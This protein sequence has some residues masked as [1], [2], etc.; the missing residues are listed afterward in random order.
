MSDGA[1]TNAL[2]LGEPLA[3]FLCSSSWFGRES[4]RV[5]YSAFMPRNGAT[6]V[7]RV[8]GLDDLEVWEIG[9]RLVAGPAGRSLHGH[10]ALQVVHVKSC[11][12]ILRADDS[13]PRHAE[14]LGWPEEKGAQR[15]AAERLAAG[16][17]LHLC[18]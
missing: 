11:S 6:S 1:V 17:D 10:A 7:F 13:P 8:A 14:I 2:A 12:L 18:R 16:S 3:R 4:G 15:F 5:K 9:R